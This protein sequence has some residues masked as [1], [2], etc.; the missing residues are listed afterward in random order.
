M[1]NIY[2]YIYTHT[3]SNAEVISGLQTLITKTLDQP[4]EEQGKQF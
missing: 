4:I 2:I 1:F 3:G